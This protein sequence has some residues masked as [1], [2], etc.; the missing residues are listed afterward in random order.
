VRV[1]AGKAA[2]TPENL[3][4]S[5][6]ALTRLAATSPQFQVR[7][8]TENWFDLLSTP[9][10]VHELMQG[11]NVGLN[12]DFGNWSSADKYAQL[13]EIAPLAEGSHAKAHFE[14]EQIDVAD[15][16]R[17][18][19]IL[20]DAHFSSPYS[21]VCDNAADRWRALGQMRAIVEGCL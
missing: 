1:I 14:N 9:E 20:R 13:A 11:L 4:Q 17:C 7:V 2:P 18:L 16:E 19:R 10:A 8:L 5:R 15:F 21:L 3:A 12:F 6:T